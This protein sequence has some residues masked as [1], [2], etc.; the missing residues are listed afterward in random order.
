[1]ADDEQRPPDRTLLQRLG[2]RGIAAIILA[3]LVLIFVLENTRS[4]K[5]RFV[6][7]EV[8][9]PLWLALVIAAGLGA[10]AAYLVEW[11]RNRR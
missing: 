7:P 10:A 2:P 11:R 4:T 3:I 6:G 1:M 5:I 8:R 9:T